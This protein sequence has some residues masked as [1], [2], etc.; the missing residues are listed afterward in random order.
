MKKIYRS[1]SVEERLPEK[2]Q[3][4]T[5]NQGTTYFDADKQSFRV[6]F[7]GDYRVTY[8]L[9]E[10]TNPNQ[11]REMVAELC[12]QFDL[13]PS[14]EQRYEHATEVE[15]KWDEVLDGFRDGANFILNHI[16]GGEK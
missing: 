3:Y 15:H 14:E 7:L 4:Y 8:W 11:A 16:K 5:T 1:V 9:E 13:L 12:E 2:E 10:I 6:P